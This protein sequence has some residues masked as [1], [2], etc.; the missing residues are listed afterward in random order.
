MEILLLPL[1][2]KEIMEVVH[3]LVQAHPIGL[4]VA[5]ALVRPEQTEHL[6]EMAETGFFPQ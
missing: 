5:V 1:Q 2:A 4:V 6:A 3:K